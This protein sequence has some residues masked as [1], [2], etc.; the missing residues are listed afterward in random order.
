MKLSRRVK[1][2]DLLNRGL[3]QVEK[4]FDHLGLIVKMIRLTIINQDG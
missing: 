1:R 3:T 2:D 4:K